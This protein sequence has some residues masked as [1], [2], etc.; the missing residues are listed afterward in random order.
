MMPDRQQTVDAIRE[1]VPEELLTLDQWVL[2]RLVER[3][4][5]PTKKPYHTGGREASSTDPATWA[6]FD[7][8]AAVFLRGGFDGLGFVFTAVDPY[9]G[10]DFDHHA[11][12][13]ALDDWALERVN[14]KFKSR[15]EYIE[16][17]APRP[18]DEMSLAEMDALWNE[19]KTAL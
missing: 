19:A 12:G 13:G 17:H 1:N 4:G 5:K 3:D 9:T 16:A 7:D 6:S 15:F 10:I 18:L 14:R 11:D 8:A 2:W